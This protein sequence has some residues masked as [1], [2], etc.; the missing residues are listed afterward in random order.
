MKRLFVLAIAGCAAIAIASPVFADST[1]GTSTTSVTL[2]GQVVDL[3]CFLSAGAH[4]DSHK[5]CATACAKAGGALG[6]LTKDGDVVVSIEPS[7]GKDP[8]ALL[9]PYVEQTVTVTGMEYD[10]HGVKS[11]AI[12]SVKP[13]AMTTG[14]AG[15]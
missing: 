5:S 15:H 4:G 6:I 12:D 10:A 9:L 3:A 1:G 11:I 14:M 2:S 8:N 7:P 13:V